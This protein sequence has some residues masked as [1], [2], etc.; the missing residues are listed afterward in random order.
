[1]LVL[2]VIA[3]QVEKATLE[4]TPPIMQAADPVA[5][6]NTITP[7]LLLSCSDAAN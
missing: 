6:E 4:H 7:I 1:M 3:E 2:G 5:P